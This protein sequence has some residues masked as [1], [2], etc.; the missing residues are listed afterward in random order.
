M[1]WTELLRACVMF[2]QNSGAVEQIRSGTP[3]HYYI[4][5]AGNEA[6]LTAARYKS[7]SIK[8]YNRQDAKYAYVACSGR[9][10]CDDRL[11]PGR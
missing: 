7:R 11:T 4:R 6:T 9:L 5:P 10:H 2:H 1:T 8:V 3:A